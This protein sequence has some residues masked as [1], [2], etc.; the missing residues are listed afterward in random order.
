MNKLKLAVVAALSAATVA[1]PALAASPLT[2]SFKV[3]ITIVSECK[4]VTASDLS[5][6]T[7]QGV[8]DANVDQTTTIK[9]TCTKGTP[10]QVALG[11]GLNG[12][13]VTDRKMKH[14]TLTD[15]IGYQLFKDSGRTLNWGSAGTD[16]LEVATATGGEQTMTVYGRVPA[17]TGT[18]PSAGAYED[19]VAVTLTY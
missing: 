3:R 10:F 16:R 2:T 9:V 18:Q 14:A 19:T 13:G 17:I 5:F 1:G 15:L 8:I 12:T 4:T 7:T 11:A 6:G